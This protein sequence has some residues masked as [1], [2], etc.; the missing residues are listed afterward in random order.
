MACLSLR[1]ELPAEENKRRRIYTLFLNLELSKK[2]SALVL[3]AAYE[4][5]IMQFEATVDKY[6]I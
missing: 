5:D 3:E 1:G 2:I 4:V 6:V